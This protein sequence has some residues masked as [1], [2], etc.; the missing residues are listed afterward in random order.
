MEAEAYQ[1]DLGGFGYLPGRFY[2]RF[3]LQHFRQRHS[4][5]LLVVARFADS[6]G[7]FPAGYSFHQFVH[8][9]SFECG[10]IC[11]PEVSDQEMTTMPNIALE[12]FEQVGNE[13]KEFRSGVESGRPKAEDAGGI[14]VHWS[15]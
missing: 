7:S 11:R 8:A 5:S 2:S 1:A 14:R 13:R 10:I 9:I 12:P 3:S 4:H 6:G 15:D